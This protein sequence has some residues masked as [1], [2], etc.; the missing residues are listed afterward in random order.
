MYTNF[1]GDGAV[2]NQATSVLYEP[3]QDMWTQDPFEL[4]MLMTAIDM[5]LQA[6]PKADNT[7]R[8]WFEKAALFAV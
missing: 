3:G 8:C 4:A 2:E 7:V 5:V 6:R 1:L